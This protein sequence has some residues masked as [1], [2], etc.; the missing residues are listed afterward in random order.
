M[1]EDVELELLEHIT[2]VPATRQRDLADVIGKSLGMTNAI[3]KR[4]VDKGWLMMG[5]VNNRNVS[6]VVTP[7]GIHVLAGRTFRYFRRTIR[8]VVYYKDKIQTDIEMWLADSGLEKTVHPDLRVTLVG[9]SDLEFIVEHLSHKLGLGFRHLA[10]L[11]EPDCLP[12][13]LMFIGENTI[14]SEQIRACQFTR[15]VFLRELVA[16]PYL[17]KTVDAP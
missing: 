3:L 14:V 8:N 5:K 9:E 16:Y 6:Y 17:E 4:L 11:T 15:F 2:Q 10:K 12:S 7:E 1:N 13:E